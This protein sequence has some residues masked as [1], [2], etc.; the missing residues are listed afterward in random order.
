MDPRWKHIGPSCFLVTSLHVSSQW[1]DTWAKHLHV[2][3]EHSVSFYT[4]QR[5][6]TDG[7]LGGLEQVAHRPRQTFPELVFVF[8]CFFIITL[9]FTDNGFPQFIDHFGSSLVLPI[10][11]DEDHLINALSALLLLN[12]LRWNRPHPRV[13]L[14]R[15]AGL[16][17]GWLSTTW[18]SGWARG[19]DSAGPVQSCLTSAIFPVIH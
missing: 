12:L 14:A 1:W 17:D 9:Q 11:R 18:S 3:K 2:H 5:L 10:K 19:P 4:A 15:Q 13:A 8:V 16:T 6:K 7:L